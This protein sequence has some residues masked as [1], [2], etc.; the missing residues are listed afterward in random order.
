MC[1]LALNK[2]GIITP[3]AFSTEY[4]IAEYQ[5]TD[6]DQRRFDAYISLRNMLGSDAI[7][8]N[9]YIRVETGGNYFL[10]SQ[11]VFTGLQTTPILY[12]PPLPNDNGLKITITQTAGTLRPF[13]YRVYSQEPDTGTA[14]P[15]PMIVQ[16]ADLV[17]VSLASIANN[18]VLTY[19]TASGKWKN[20]VPTGGGGGTGDMILA[21]AQLNT[22]VKTFSDGTL[23]LRNTA[24]TQSV[25]LSAGSNV[26]AGVV[27]TLPTATTS[28]TI[29]TGG[30]TQTL[31]N[32]NISGSSNTL[33]NIPKSAIPSSV[34]YND[35]DNDLG[36]HFAKLTAIAAPGTPTT[37]QIFAW[38]DSTSGH[39]TVKHSDGST[40]DLEAATGGGGGSGDMLL[41]TAQ[42]VTASKTFNDGTL[43]L[44]NPAGTFGTTVKSGAQPAARTFTHP[45]TGGNDNYVL[46]AVAQTLSSKTL[47]APVLSTYIDFTRTTAPG[48]P[49]ANFGRAY[50]KQIDTNNDGLFILLKKAGSYVEVQI[51]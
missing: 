5:T 47:A 43:I 18:D 8:I 48:N 31:S 12:L 21:S 41:G 28:Q 9:V 38:L 10:Y 29:T 50:C 1:G 11:E 25:A 35:V 20:K 27:F 42:T 13:P 36:A 3:T 14:T 26:T 16:L 6:A 37:N 24:G 46:E 45:V 22:G 15:P 39:L 2:V 30:T 44:N 7:T 19:E 32:K 17:D 33:T 49:A 23:A 4:T 51:A 34:L 40:K